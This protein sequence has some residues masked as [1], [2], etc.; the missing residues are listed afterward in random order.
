MYLNILE[1]TEK[2]PLKLNTKAK[3]AFSYSFRKR[4]SV[5]CIS[6]VAFKIAIQFMQYIPN[7]RIN[8]NQITTARKGYERR[9]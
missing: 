6:D 9:R 3:V 2:M 4:F 7:T 5:F 1:F 8:E